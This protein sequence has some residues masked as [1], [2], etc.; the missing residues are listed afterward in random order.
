M[1]VPPEEKDP[2]VLQ[3]PTRRS[4]ALFGA[5]NLRD[6]RL[7]SFLTPIFDALSFEVFLGQLWRQRRRGRPMVVVTDNAPYHH[8]GDLDPFL[9]AHRALRLDFLP[10]Y[11]PQLNPI[12]RVWKLLRRLCTHNVYFETLEKLTDTVC[13]QLVAW[14]EPNAVLEKLCCII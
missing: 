12:E 9:A 3:E 13:R 11:S 6:G 7:V 14:S 8:S 5:V 4:V 1:W 10:P 2:F